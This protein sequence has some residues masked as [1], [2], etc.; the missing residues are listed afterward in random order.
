MVIGSILGSIG[1]SLFV[2][3]FLVG[4]LIAAVLAIKW[5]RCDRGPSKEK[6]SLADMIS[7]QDRTVADAIRNSRRQ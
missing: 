1:S 4:A 6:I 3:I 2:G 5:V 7:S